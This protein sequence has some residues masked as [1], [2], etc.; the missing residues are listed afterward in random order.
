MKTVLASS[1][2]NEIIRNRLLVCFVIPFLVM[3]S[4][5]ATAQSN[6]E[7][8]FDLWLGFSTTT[9]TISFTGPATALNDGLD[10]KIGAGLHL[11]AN[12][13]M[14]RQLALR[15]GFTYQYFDWEV[16]D[17]LSPVTTETG[18]PTGEAILTTLTRDFN[19]MYAGVPLH[20]RFYPYASHF[21]ITAGADFWYK[22][23]YKAGRL[24][25]FFLDEDGLF[26]QELGRE[27]YPTPRLA[28]DFVIAGMAGIGFA[29]NL[30]NLRMGL[31]LYSRQNITPFVNSGG[32][33]QNFTQYGLSLFV[34]L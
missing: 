12:W 31:E 18:D 20:L 25:T 16:K 6:S 29:F 28:S 33:K 19:L 8:S 7:R 10:Y 15:T 4:S 17:K 11:H 21:Y 26:V 32:V 9:Q 13:Y 34:R 1:P 3:A 14:F 5:P 30:E 24:D 2:L 23:T 22:F 27:P